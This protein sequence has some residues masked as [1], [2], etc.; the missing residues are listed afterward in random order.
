MSDDYSCDSCYEQQCVCNIL[1]KL[2]AMSKNIEAIKSNTKRDLFK[3]AGEKPIVV[4]LDHVVAITLDGSRIS[5][6]F[7]SNGVFIDVDTPE[8]ASS[9]YEQL[10]NLW[11]GDV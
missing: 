10:L 2:D 11:A 5:C 7:H 3:S 1:D 6:M 8:G 9:L 4:N